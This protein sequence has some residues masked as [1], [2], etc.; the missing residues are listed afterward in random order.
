MKVEFQI[1][2]KP[3]AKQRVHSVPMAV[4][5]SCKRRGAFRREGCKYC[6][7]VMTFIANIGITPNETKSYEN[8]V[9]S[10]AAEAKPADFRFGEKALRVAVVFHFEIPQ[11]R[12]KKLKA[13]DHHTQRPDVDNLKKSILDGCNRVLWTDDCIVAEIHARKEW[14]PVNEALVTVE[15]L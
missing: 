2:G 12:I 6:G 4:C 11:S 7:A 10:R 5:N 13:G 3:Q 9:A 8:W 14:W 1:P 15:E